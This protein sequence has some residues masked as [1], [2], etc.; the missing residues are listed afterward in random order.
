[1]V[2]NAIQYVHVFMYMYGG[3]VG[4]FRMKLEGNYSSCSGIVVFYSFGSRI[5]KDKLNQMSTIL[6]PNCIEEK[7]IDSGKAG[8][9]DNCDPYFK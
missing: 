7:C 9:R 4:R 6:K 1:M 5:S 8:S 3:R 2:I